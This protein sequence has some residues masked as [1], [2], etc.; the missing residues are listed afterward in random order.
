MASFPVNLA[1]IEKKFPKGMTVPLLL[2][3]FAQWVS[4]IQQGALGYFEVMS[5]GKFRDDALSGDA[6]KKIAQARGSS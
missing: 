4:K 3:A 6:N 2:K 1:S 5:G